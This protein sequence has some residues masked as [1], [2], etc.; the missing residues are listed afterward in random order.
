MSRAFMAAIVVALI[1]SAGWALAAAQG[2][3][4]MPSYL[5]GWLFW[6]A[7]PLGALPLVM[8]MELLRVGDPAILLPLRRILLLLPF[9]AVF[10]IPVLLRQTELFAR[11][12]LPDALPAAWM[13]PGFF[14]A[15]MI[16]YLVIWAVLAL[17]FCSVP[18]ER[19][20]E[21]RRGIAGFGLMLHLVIGSLAAFDWIMA[22]EP[23]VG[24]SEFG[25]LVISAQISIACCVAMMAAALGSLAPRPIAGLAL[26]TLGLWLFLHFVQYLV[27]W[28]ANLPREIVWYQHRAAGLGEPAAWFAAAACALA[29]LALAPRASAARPWVLASVASM[30]LLMHLVEMLW[31]VTPGFRGAFVV[32][33]PDILAV[34]GLGG[35]AACVMIPARRE[36]AHA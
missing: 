23:G 14:T 27:I 2:D 19:N 1:G 33:L 9:A 18:T 35:L 3:A 22:L 28:S 29:L 8:A 7:L 31:L 16:A 12:D 34:L 25:L 32:T 24:S 17:L 20:V 26:S 30:L 6:I 10:V 15:R 5:A 13:N 4:V 11:P 21:R 36:R